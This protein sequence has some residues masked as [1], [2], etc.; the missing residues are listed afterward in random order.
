ML[1]LEDSLIRSKHQKLLNLNKNSL[2]TLSQVT[3]PYSKESRG[4]FNIN[5]KFSTGELSKADDAELKSILEAFIPEAGLAM[6]A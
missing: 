5:I 3:Q 2:N 1:V 4:F 6:K